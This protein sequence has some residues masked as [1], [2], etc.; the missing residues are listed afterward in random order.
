M[1]RRPRLRA[2]LAAVP[3]LLVLPLAGPLPATAAPAAV[4]TGA[5]VATTGTL[6]SADDTAAREGEP[7]VVT[8]RN[9][10]GL[11]FDQCHTPDQK[12][13]NTWWRASPYQAVGVYASGKSRACRDQPNLTAEWVA[14]QS[15]TGWRILPI[16]LGPQAS[17]NPRFP[18]YRNDETVNP[19]PGK[20]GRYDLA[21]EQGVKSAS[22]AVNKAADLGIAAGST[23]WYDMEGFDLGN[24]N[25][26][27]SALSFLDGW[28]DRIH[29]LGYVSG[30]YSS[31]GSG[32]K[33]LDGARQNRPHRFSMPDRVWIADWDGQQNLTSTSLSNT[34]W[35]DGDRMKQYRGGHDETWGGVTINIDSS[36][37]DLGKGTRAPD[38]AEVCNGTQISYRD[39]MNLS[40]TRTASDGSTV[41]ADE[42]R[43]A[44]LQCV[45]R[46]DGFAGGRTDGEYDAELISVVRSWQR[47]HGFDESRT[48]SRENWVAALSEYARGTRLKFGDGSN[49]VR[50]LQRTLNAVAA[51]I[52][53]PVNGLYLAATTKAVKQ[54]QRRVGLEATGIITG[55]QWRLLKQGQR[56]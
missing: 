16:T 55:P 21:Y 25:C 52:R 30:V 47:H 46:L 51:K 53:T 1:T 5:T 17:C 34:G 6:A 24:K 4:R 40:P 8:P 38:E 23:L 18:R 10:T 41:V 37:L 2:L 45:L 48:W 35:T 15:S 3:L 33:A 19:R 31:A 11:A 44:A 7:G 32:I 9:L 14:K 49:Q 43:T 36:Y 56:S 50:Y 12:T 27:E 20:N 39:Y 26:R 13:M 42:S 29:T 54:W 28:T 22:G